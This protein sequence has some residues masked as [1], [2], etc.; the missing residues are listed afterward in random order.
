MLPPVEFDSGLVLNEQV[1]EL[2]AHIA[3]KSKWFYLT[4]S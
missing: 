1:T 3:L 4:F 2:G